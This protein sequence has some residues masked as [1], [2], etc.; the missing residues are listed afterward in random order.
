MRPYRV[1]DL[2]PCIERLQPAD[3][4]DT[5]PTNKGFD[6]E[7][8]VR[9]LFPSIRLLTRVRALRQRGCPFERTGSALRGHTGAA[10]GEIRTQ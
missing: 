4:I 3:V 9:A 5:H 8:A 7:A 6:F 2:A 1:V 10:T